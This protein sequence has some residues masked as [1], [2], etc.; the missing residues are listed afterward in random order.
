MFTKYETKAKGKQMRRTNGSDN[1]NVDKD[2]RKR[3][4]RGK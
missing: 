3:R 1:R 2:I 4:K